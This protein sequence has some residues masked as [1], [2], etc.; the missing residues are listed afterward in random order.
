[1][2]SL[3]YF[4]LF[5]VGFIVALQWAS[6]AVLVGLVPRRWGGIVMVWAGRDGLLAHWV[7]FCQLI[8]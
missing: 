5:F 1:M 6:A 7:D 2:H 8:S 3:F 4:I